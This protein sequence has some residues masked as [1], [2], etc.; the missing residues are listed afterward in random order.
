M[1]SIA[2]EVCAAVGEPRAPSLIAPAHPLTLCA[3]AAQEKPM[4]MASKNSSLRYASFAGVIAA[5]LA[6]SSSNPSPPEGSPRQLGACTPIGAATCGA[7]PVGGGT[8]APSRDAGTPPVVT[9]V[10]DAGNCP[11]VTAIFGAAGSS[12]A[13][14][15]QNQCCLSPTSCPN[16]PACLSIA[17]CVA[18]TC[19]QNDQSCLVTCEGASPPDT[20]NEYIAFQQCVGANC[21]GCPALRAGDL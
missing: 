6:C 13:A 18:M 17:V 3:T 7:R 11:G 5:L 9:T 1:A 15:V 8:T 21:P 4:A 12:C 2:R 10:T 20:I 14:C 16:D 19:L